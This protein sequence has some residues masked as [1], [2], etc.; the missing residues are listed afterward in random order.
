MEGNINNMN[1]LVCDK[2]R[3][4]GKMPRFQ[5]LLQKMSAK[6]GNAMASI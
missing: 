5:I 2:T 1:Y 4:T 3:Y 6:H